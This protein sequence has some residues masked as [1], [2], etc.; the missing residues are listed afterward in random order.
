[1][2]IVKNMRN[3]PRQM[4]DIDGYNTIMK[5][6][7]ASIPSEEPPYEEFSD[8]S[9]EL[10]RQE[11]P[12]AIGYF[13]WGPVQIEE[14]LWVLCRNG[15]VWMSNSPRELESMQYAIYRAKGTVVI[16]GLGMGWVAWK[17]ALKDSVDEVIV[18]EKDEE[19]IEMFPK[20]IGGAEPPFT[21]HQGDIFDVRMS[22]LGV[23]DV[24]FMF[25]DIW[26]VIGTDTTLP[27]ARKIHVSIPAKELNY[28]GQE[29]DIGMFS[30]E[31][32]PL[33][34]D[35]EKLD[36]MSL[37]SSVLSN[38]KDDNFKKALSRVGTDVVNKFIDSVELP[39]SGRDE[40]GYGGLCSIVTANSM[41]EF[42]NANTLLRLAG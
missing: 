3:K 33:L 27:E 13:S 42:M 4:I 5:K 37:M 34:T 11:V 16:G 35:D 12:A 1:M 25:L 38:E 18:I 21:I 32:G 40:D 20:M 14:P 19:L 26:A 24:D 39:L 10:S 29:S 8:A 17:C 28:W 22:D 9:W 7:K 31:N 30:L 41:M 2:V 15:Q 36:L 6:I 23:E